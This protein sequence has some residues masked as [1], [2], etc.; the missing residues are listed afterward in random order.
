MPYLVFATLFVAATAFFLAVQ[1]STAQDEA[2]VDDLF[3]SA[4]Q[5][6]ERSRWAA[7]GEGL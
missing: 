4:G 6:M 3:E 1:S 7:K 2:E 5:R